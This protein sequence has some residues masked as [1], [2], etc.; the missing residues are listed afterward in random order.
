MF[1]TICALIRGV[2]K[3]P[4]SDHGFDVIDVL[5]GFNEAEATMQVLTLYLCCWFAAHKHEKLNASACCCSH[6]DILMLAFRLQ[7]LTEQLNGFIL[8]DQYPLSL[9]T[10]SLQVYLVLVTVST[11]QFKSIHVKTLV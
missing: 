7:N 6:P 2:F 1:Q 4:S 5:I 9:K 8:G 10:L 3:T 11:M